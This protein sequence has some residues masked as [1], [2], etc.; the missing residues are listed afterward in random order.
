MTQT[1][2]ETENAIDVLVQHFLMDQ[3]KTGGQIIAAFEH[4]GA[5]VQTSQEPFRA[6]GAAALAAM[7]NKDLAVLHGRKAVLLA[8]LPKQGPA[9]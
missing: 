5:A 4:M 6:M 1:T 3:E 2:T 9:Q 7:M 8:S